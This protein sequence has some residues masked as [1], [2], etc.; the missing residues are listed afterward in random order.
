MRNKNGK[1]DYR[2][3]INYIFLI[4]QLLNSSRLFRTGAPVLLGLVKCPYEVPG[5][6][7]SISG[8]DTAGGDHPVPHPLQAIEHLPGGDAELHNFLLVIVSLGLIWHLL[9][10]LPRLECDVKVMKV[11]KSDQPRDGWGRWQWPTTWWRSPVNKATTISLLAAPSVP[12]G[13]W[14][15][16]PGRAAPSCA[17]RCGWGRSSP[18]CGHYGRCSRTSWLGCQLMARSDGTGLRLGLPARPLAWHWEEWPGQ[19]SVSV[20]TIVY[21]GFVSNIPTLNLH[22]K[23]GQNF[24]FFISISN[25]FGTP[26]CP[27]KR[28]S[29]FVFWGNE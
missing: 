20:N 8:D 13:L 28:T 5:V 25:N 14:C 15:R 22:H 21:Q 16:P 4:V 3:I 26:L 19:A 12:P 2:F 1:S 10:E 11:N 17:P 24:L 9:R 6:V 29:I 18:S 7:L 27:N 23:K